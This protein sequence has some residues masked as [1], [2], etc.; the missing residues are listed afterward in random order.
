MLDH[1]STD[2]S[3]DGLGVR[4]ERMGRSALD[5]D[6]RAALVSDCVRE[7]LRRYDAVV[8]SDADELAIA[9][10]ARYANLVE[11][12]A[13]APDVTTAIG[14]DLQHLPEEE[15]GLAVAEPIGGQR[16]WVRFSAAMCKP[17]LV[18]QPVRWGAGFH[19]C[20]GPRVTD[21]LYL[22]H[23]RF[24]DLGIGLER[25]ART[26]AQ[27]FATAETNLHQRVADEE[28]EQMMRAVARLP[29]E[30]GSLAPVG[31]VEEGW[32]ER[33]REGWAR[34]DRQLSLAGDV[35]WRLPAE[36]LRLF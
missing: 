9:D 11:Y 7:L 3:T 8:H 5:E 19:D 22:L 18:K 27:N 24:A 32:L 2:G 12:A 21:S 20:D 33:M 25:L 31:G 34:G 35:L 14:F 36:V 1:G 30:E 16:Q 10:P 23:L 6:A 17:A 28:F 15:G 26:R 13:A 29:R 4:V